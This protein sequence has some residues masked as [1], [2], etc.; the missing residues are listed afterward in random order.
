MTVL[1]RIPDQMVP[2]PVPLQI[3]I[4]VHMIHVDP[5][6]HIISLLVYLSFSFVRLRRCLHIGLLFPL[7]FVYYPLHH[8]PLHPIIDHR[9]TRFNIIVHTLSKNLEFYK[10]NFS[11]LRFIVLK[12]LGDEEKKT[13]KNDKRSSSVSLPPVKGNNEQ[14]SKSTAALQHHQ[15][16]RNPSYRI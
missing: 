2:S 3:R 5:P 13:T 4:N 15:Q 7:D 12:G 6:S 9:E 14:H 8:Y 1:Q 10:N 16:R 11:V